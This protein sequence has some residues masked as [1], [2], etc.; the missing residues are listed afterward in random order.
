MPRVAFEYWSDPLCIWALVAQPK[1]DQILDEAGD[2]LE[3]RYHVVPVFGS[4]PWRFREGPWSQGGVAGR[5]EATRRIARE[6]G[7]DDV[8]GDCWL[9]DCPAS[10]W[11]A[12][13]AVKA[14]FAIEEAGQVPTGS[15]TRYLRSMREMFFVEQ[16]N[17]ARRDVQLELAERLGMPQSALEAALNDGTALAA[18][19]ED[20][21]RK[22]ELK[23]QGSPT[24]VFDGGRAM[25][26]GNFSFGVL[27]ATV[28]EML[29]SSE[30]GA[31]RC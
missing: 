29:S 28:Q 11:A 25:L 3:V 30:T 12:G 14:A 8:A 6:H 1:L 19:W 16:R 7:R 31:S 17:V 21:R 24:Y 15:A 2:R 13:A 5:A 20:D 27:H 18:L 23:I 10:S 4:I 26:Y 22:T 9:G